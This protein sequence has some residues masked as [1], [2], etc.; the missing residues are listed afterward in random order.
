MSRLVVFSPRAA[1]DLDEIFIYVAADNLSA[2]SRLIQMLEEACMLF[3]EHP[4]IGQ[5]RTEFSGEIRSFSRGSYVIFYRVTADRVEIVRI[6]HG[7]RDQT[8]LIE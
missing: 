4:A 7:A 5:R 8:G 6:L 1:N 2:A 3:G